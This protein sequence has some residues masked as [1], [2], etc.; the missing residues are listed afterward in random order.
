MGTVII[1]LV[2][3]LWEKHPLDVYLLD[4]PESENEYN[5]DI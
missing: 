1:T 5:S 2:P 4:H 3:R